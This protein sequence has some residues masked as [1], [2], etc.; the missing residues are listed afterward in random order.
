MKAS[1]AVMNAYDP[2]K[3]W[4]TGPHPVILG[5]RY[6]NRRPVAEYD[7][8]GRGGTSWKMKDMSGI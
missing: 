5:E 6:V 3:D 2:E 4:N 7:F 1:E 8:A